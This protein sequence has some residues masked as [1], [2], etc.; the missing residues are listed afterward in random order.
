MKISRRSFLTLLLLVLLVHQRGSAAEDLVRREWKV[1]EVVREALVYVPE[2]AKTNTAPVVFVFH[3]HAG[4]MQ[5]TVRTFRIHTLWPEAIVVYP[6]G[7]NTP[8]RLTDPEGKKPGWQHGAGAQGDRDLKFFDAMLTS[9]K[10]DYKVDGKRMYSTGHSNG[11]GFTY[12]LWATRGEH[13]AA[14]APSAAAASA[15]GRELSLDQ[16]STAYSVPKD[17]AARSNPADKASAVEKSASAVANMAPKPQPFLHLGAENDPLV[18][19]AWQKSTIDRLREFNQCGDGKP[20]KDENGA[21]QYLSKIG[22]PVVVYLHDGGHK[23][24]DKGPELIVKF[25]KENAQP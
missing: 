1:D 21:T 2:R 10:K 14:Y 22:A 15:I 17:E 3:G 24:P 11:G 4:S 5:N 8:G 16:K 18:K 25:F 9:L 7:L 12:L 23:F 6:Q 19:F 20:W 13:F